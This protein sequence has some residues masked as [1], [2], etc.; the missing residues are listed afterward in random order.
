MARHEHQ[1]ERVVVL[2]RR[3]QVAGLPRA[4]GRLAVTP[5]G[6][7][8]GSIDDPQRRDVDQPADGVRGRAL[9]W[10]LLGRREHRL[11]GCV[12][13][14]GKVTESPPDRSED[15][16]RGVAHQVLDLSRSAHCSGIG[17]PITSRTSI[18]VLIGLPPGPGAAEASAAISIARSSDSTSIIR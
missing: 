10:P 6:V 8:A 2:R 1:R 9:A 11:L 14:V 15:P 3:G 12:L 18:T 13:G 7:A 5:R 4:G 17:A 16:R